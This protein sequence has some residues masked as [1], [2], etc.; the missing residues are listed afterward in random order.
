MGHEKGPPGSTG[1]VIGGSTT[2]RRMQRLVAVGDSLVNADRSWAFHLADANDYELS[3][4]SVGGTNSQMVLDQLPQIDG[5]HYAVGALSVGTND[6]FADLTVGQYAD[7]LKRIVSAMAE[8]CDQVVMQT[9]PAVTGSVVGAAPSIRR[10]V[11]D[12][13]AAIRSQPGVVLVDAEDLAGRDLMGPDRVHP[14]ERGQIVIYRRAS[15]ALGL[16]IL[17]REAISPTPG[18]A[19]AVKSSVL[20][21]GRRLRR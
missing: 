17:E 3:R 19:L 1:L 16:P 20:A 2:L 7:N 8:V 11:A 13:N 21:I 12:I 5:Q 15:E 9:L 6:V 10:K 14:T 18:P 4:T